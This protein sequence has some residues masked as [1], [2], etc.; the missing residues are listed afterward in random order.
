[1]DLET[2]LSC[3]TFI[4]RAN[5][6]SLWLHRRSYVKKEKRW[7]IPK[8]QGFVFSSECAVRL[9]TTCTIKVR[10]T[11][12]LIQN[13]QESNRIRASVSLSLAS[14]VHCPYTVKS[15]QVSPSRPGLSI[16]FS[17]YTPRPILGNTYLSYHFCLP[18]RL[19]D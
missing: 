12:P 16:T 18:A 2:K 15:P 8:I 9:A 11:S 14:L 7:V 5:T 1:M 3:S 19:F 4:Y 17:F 10:H 13:C 6:W